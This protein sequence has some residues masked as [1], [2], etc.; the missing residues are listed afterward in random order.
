MGEALKRRLKQA[1]FANPQQEAT[2]SLF[3]AASHL[4]SRFDR[5]MAGFGIS[6]EQYNILR[7]LKGV[8]PGGHACGE[9]AERMLDR[10]PDITRR[11]DGLVKMGLVERNRSEEDRRVVMTQ[12][13]TGGIELLDRV[14]RRLQET[15]GK[16][17]S[18]LSQEE[19]HELARLCERLFED[20]V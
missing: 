7:I 15:E 12:I 3:V 5:M 18:K 16:I 19:W 13:S 17:E 11:I 6:H 20:E 9:I 4:R 10:S 1:K 8:H 14:S 2:L